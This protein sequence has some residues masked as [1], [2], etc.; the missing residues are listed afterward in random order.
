MM[1]KVKTT[2]GE[3]F[4]LEDK[5]IAKE[6]ANFLV[7]RKKPGSQQYLDAMFKEEFEWGLQHTDAL[8]EYADQILKWDD[9]F[10]SV[11]ESE[12]ID[13]DPSLEIYSVTQ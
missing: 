8:L 2:D 12:W 7:N 1:F 5:W 6:R 10:E 4:N 9:I 3:E 13:L 11:E